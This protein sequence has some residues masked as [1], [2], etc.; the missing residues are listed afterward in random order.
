MKDVKVLNGF[1]GIYTTWT[2][3]SRH[4]TNQVIG[5]STWYKFHYTHWELLL[6]SFF[7]RWDTPETMTPRLLLWVKKLD[8]RVIVLRPTGVHALVRLPKACWGDLN[9]VMVET[10]VQ[11]KTG[12]VWTFLK[13]LCLSHL[14]DS[15]CQGFLSILFFNQLYQPWAEILGQPNTVNWKNHGA[16]WLI[17]FLVSKNN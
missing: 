1:S 14:K 15:L 17:F 10:A 5:T 13:K 12:L 8:N 4:N 3:C 16:I 9:S 6:P 11:V 7:D 2:T